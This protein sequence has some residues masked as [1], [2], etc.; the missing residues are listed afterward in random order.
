MSGRGHVP[1]V[2]GRRPPVAEGARHDWGVHGKKQQEQRV[3][4]NKFGQGVSG[5]SHESEHPMQ[6]GLFAKQAG[7]TRRQV[8]KPLPAYQEVKEWHRGHAGTGGGNKSYDTG[9]GDGETS[10]GKSKQEKKL[11]KQNDQRIARSFGVG[12]DGDTTSAGIYR[13]HQTQALTEGSV[14]NAVQ[15]QQLGMAF[16][17]NE[18]QLATDKGAN[19]TRVQQANDSYLAM[20]RGMGRDGDVRFGDANIGISHNDIAEMLLARKAAM[21]GEWPSQQDIAD[22][23]DWVRDNTA[24]APAAPIVAPAAAAA[25]APPIVA[26]AAPAVPA[27]PIVAP[28]PERGRGVKRTGAGQDRYGKRP[29]TE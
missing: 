4:T 28:A 7:K 27:A 13:G 21:T 20:L 16:S 9:F 8:E 25:P 23:R 29:R 11:N 14:S 12:T 10:R 18:V 15:L 17:K 2:D 1:K 26:P 19:P 3:L 5:V 6:A 22:A 24:P